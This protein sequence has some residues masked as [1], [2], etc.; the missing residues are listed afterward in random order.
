MAL[1]RVISRL[2]PS[3]DFSADVPLLPR[4]SA[5]SLQS[6]QPKIDLEAFQQMLQQDLELQ[7]H[8]RLE[9][10]ILKA[11][12]AP[13]LYSAELKVTSDCD[14]FVANLFDP[15]HE[16]LLSMQLNIDTST[17]MA[18]A[19]AAVLPLLLLLVLRHYY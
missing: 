15:T 6:F 16:L 18:T 9:L 11:D 13:F 4:K 5:L 7:L 3:I 1:N 17:A 10:N 2:D 8:M 14:K 19:S 12:T